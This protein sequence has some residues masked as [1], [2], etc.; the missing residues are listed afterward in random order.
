M[1]RMAHHIAPSGLPE[2]PKPI[3]SPSR[4][5]L[6][7]TG[8]TSLLT[9]ASGRRTP[10][11]TRDPTSSTSA[12][13][14]VRGANKP[15]TP[16]SGALKLSAMLPRLLQ[17]RPTYSRTTETPRP[18]TDALNASRMTETSKF[19][20]QLP[21]QSKNF[22]EVVATNK[23]NLSLSPSTHQDSRPISPAS[24]VNPTEIDIFSDDDLC[25]STDVNIAISK[26]EDEL[27]TLTDAFHA[28]ETR[29]QRHN[30]KQKA[31]RL[32]TNTPANVDILFSGKEWREH[33]RIPSIPP[34]SYL[35]DS[36]HRRLFAPTALDSLASDTT[37]LHS[38][39]SNRTD[40]SQ[41]RSAASF[42]R[43]GSPSRSTPAPSNTGSPLQAFALSNSFG[44]RKLT[45]PRKNSISS[46]MTSASS[47]NSKSG[48]LNR[49]ESLHPPKSSSSAT[50][51]LRL[52]SM[53]SQSK[54]HLGLKNLKGSSWM[55]SEETL[56]SVSSSSREETRIL[57]S[58]CGQ[59]TSGTE[60]ENDPVLI[61]IRRRKEELIARYNARLEFLRA[62]LKSVELHE[63]LLRK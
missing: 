9:K 62:K 12:L 21:P 32:P 38:A 56:L 52:S 29:T 47:F 51:S 49:S 43:I 24:S 4:S 37:S 10:K 22:L 33:R 36:C 54:S 30:L 6:N 17:R 8:V 23:S 48:I 19:P 45:A 34:S 11:H 20:S 58:S 1:S 16:G 5:K 2:T 59:G 44:K 53:L 63:R 26:T 3:P 57:G 41:A 18:L 40:L 27:L 42:H 15:I 13:R 55:F 25:T 31:D 39:S 7:I 60:I 61:D 14:E 35:L 50:G 46:T 28:L